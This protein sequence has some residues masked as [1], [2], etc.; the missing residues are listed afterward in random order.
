MILFPSL[1]TRISKRERIS[2]SSKKP[3]GLKVSF[4]LF[5]FWN[6]VCLEYSQISLTE[7]INTSFIHKNS[8][9]TSI[10][11]I[12]IHKAYHPYFGMVRRRGKIKGR[13][14]F[15]ELLSGLATKNIA[16]K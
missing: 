14:V 9:T 7:K 11:S 8:Q 3:M 13:E 10:N 15:C 1:T 5:R 4:F 12:E 6:L 2:Q 16:R